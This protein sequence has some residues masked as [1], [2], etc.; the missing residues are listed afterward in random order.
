MNNHLVRD[1]SQYITGDTITVY[2]FCLE[3]VRRQV[4]ERFANHVITTSIN[5][6]SP[7]KFVKKRIC[8]CIIAGEIKEVARE[9]W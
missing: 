3:I 6:C 1:F 5:K 8:I 7:A 9:S 2:K 4:M